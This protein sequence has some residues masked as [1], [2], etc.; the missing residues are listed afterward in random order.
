MKIH[1]DKVDMSGYDANQRDWGGH[2]L[3]C[4]AKMLVLCATCG[5]GGCYNCSNG[6]V[7]DE[8]LCDCS[9]ETA[10]GEGDGA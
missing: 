7:L 10:R 3:A 8:S 9:P 2:T 5:G 4:L 1:L 6:G